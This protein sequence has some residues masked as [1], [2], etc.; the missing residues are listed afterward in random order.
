MDAFYAF[1]NRL[2]QLKRVIS[3]LHKIHHPRAHFGLG[4]R[5]IKPLKQCCKCRNTRGVRLV[6]P[7]AH[8]PVPARPFTYGKVKFVIKK[9]GIDPTARQVAHGLRNRGG[10]H[11][12]MPD[13]KRRIGL[14]PI[15]KQGS[16][17]VFAALEI[18]IETGPRHSQTVADRQ[19]FDLAHAF[20]DQQLQGHGQPIFA[21]NFGVAV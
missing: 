1:L 13:Q 15:L 8:G 2:G 20:A 11:I 16:Q 4:W 21:G 9:R 14:F 5:E 6:N 19:Y 7:A 17:Q 18:P 3:D 12:G 10:G